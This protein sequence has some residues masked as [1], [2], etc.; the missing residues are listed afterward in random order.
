M[1]EI[2]S[3]SDF[4]KGVTLI[5]KIPESDLDQKALYTITSDKPDFILPFNHKTVDGQVEFIYE[6]GNQ[7]K[8][9]YLSG[10][11]SPNEY[12]NL[13]INIL[14]PLIDCDDWFM[15]PY[16]FV[17]KLDY[18]YCDKDNK[19][20]NFVY[21][22][23]KKRYSDD[24]MLKDMITDIAKH[25]HISDVNFENKI[26]WAIQDFNINEFLKIVKS[27]GVDNIQQISHE[28]ISEPMQVT[29]EPV[30]K[31][32]EQSAVSVEPKES[33]RPD[34]FK[35]SVGLD[36]KLDDI[37]I[38]I[39]NN[40]NVKPD[41]KKKRKAGLF[42]F[43]REKEANPKGNPRDKVDFSDKK[44]KEKKDNKQK[45]IVQGAAAAM[46]EKP[47][48]ENKQHIL[49]ENLPPENSDDVTQF[50]ISESGVSKLCYVGNGG[51]PNVIVVDI[52]E[53]GFFTIGRFDV[54]VGKQQSSFEFDKKTKAISRRH[55][56]IKRDEEG[57][58]ILDLSSSAGTIVNGEKLIPNMPR[59]LE[60]GS[61]VSFGHLGAD[62]V[63]NE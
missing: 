21:I 7:N 13:W 31:T 49:V 59:K 30:Q 38:N 20:M 12:I 63:W 29:R 8:L 62:Y 37:V 16:S 58:K 24:D 33:Q 41:K 60:S 3:S 43:R 35:I 15:N 42:G 17:F 2:H 48:A 53:G 61:R 45:E 6:I 5:V 23:S 44:N 19:N 54:S 27:Y 56:V 40:D 18:L 9:V 52:A 32:Y 39:D 26:I 22:P 55:A 47:K 25:N 57:Y 51:H 36:G 14:Q 50:D 11:R 4:Q 46:F 1:Y 10:D 34:K 28:S